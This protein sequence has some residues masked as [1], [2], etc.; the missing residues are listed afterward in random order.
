[1]ILTLTPGEWRLDWSWMQAIYVIL[2]ITSA[3]CQ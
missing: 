1:M 2:Y 3:K